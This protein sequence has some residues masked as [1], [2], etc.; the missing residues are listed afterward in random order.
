MDKNGGQQVL[1]ALPEP[2]FKPSLP[3]YT[4]SHCKIKTT[5]THTFPQKDE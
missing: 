4:F 5:A 1:L 3:H 2:L